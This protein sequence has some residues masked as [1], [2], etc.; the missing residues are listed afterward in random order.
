MSVDDDVELGAC[1][2]VS[3][4]GLDELLFDESISEGE[5]DSLTAAAVLTGT[6]TRAV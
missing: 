2:I 4:S 3:E 1:E 6:T 5:L